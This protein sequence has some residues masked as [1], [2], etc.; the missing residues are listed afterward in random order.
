VLY[1][2]ASDQRSDDGANRN[3]GDSCELGVMFAHGLEYAVLQHEDA[4]FVGSIG[5]KG[6]SFT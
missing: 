3:A 6:L 2:V 4:V 5:L 1:R